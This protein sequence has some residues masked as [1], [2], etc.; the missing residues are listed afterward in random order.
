MLELSPQ[1]RHRL[2]KPIDFGRAINRLLHDDL[3]PQLFERKF[4]G[5]ALIDGWL[6]VTF[7]DGFRTV[8]LDDRFSAMHL[9]PCGLV[10]PFAGTGNEDILLSASYHPGQNNYSY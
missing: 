8:F 3:D 4:H 6:P 7:Q 9:S 1:L 2:L 5:S 10:V